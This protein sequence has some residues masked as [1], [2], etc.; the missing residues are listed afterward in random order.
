MYNSRILHFLIESISRRCLYFSK[1]L[2]DLKHPLT[3]LAVRVMSEQAVDS[4]KQSGQ[5]KL[6]KLAVGP[7]LDQSGPVVPSFA[8]PAQLA[9]L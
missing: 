2:L 9:L 8:T 7:G 3:S 6:V 1:N 4:G 5:V